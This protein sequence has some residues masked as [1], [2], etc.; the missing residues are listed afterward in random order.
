MNDLLERLYREIDH[1]LPGIEDSPKLQE[2]SAKLQDI[3]RERGLT[4]IE[5]E[6]ALYGIKYQAERQGFVMGFQ[7]ALELLINHKEG[8]DGEP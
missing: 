2:E 7:F 4:E 1:L 6:N 5:A 8:A 3:L